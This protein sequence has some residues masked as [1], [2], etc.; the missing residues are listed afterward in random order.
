VMTPSLESVEDKGKGAT[1]VAKVS[2]ATADGQPVNDQ[3]ATIFVR[4]AGSGT[5]RPP[6]ERAEMPERGAVLATFV[7]HV[8]EDMPT[9]YAEASGDHN[10][11]HLDPAVATMVGLPGVINH[12]L[13]TLSLVTAGL[14]EHLA[15]GDPTRMSRIAVRFTDVV[16]PG[17]DLV[18]SA[19]GSTP[20]TLFET[21]RPDGRVVMSGAVDIS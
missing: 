4:G 3:Y 17:S 15:D 14:V 5:E 19:W 16:I 12:G 2:S 1:F 11:I 6:S 18:T 7:S 9:R 20:S 21:T 10:P 8:D 13:G